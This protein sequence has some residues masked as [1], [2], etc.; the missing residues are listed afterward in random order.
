MCDAC[1]CFLCIFLSMGLSDGMVCV[2]KQ[3]SVSYSR[4][5]RTSNLCHDC[6]SSS[7]V[8]FF[9]HVFVFVFF[10]STEGFTN[11]S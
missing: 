4:A 10:T 1:F 6:A 8:A 11:E 7:R 3:K 2:E 5:C 9:H